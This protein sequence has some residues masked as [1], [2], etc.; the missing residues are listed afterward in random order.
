MHGA[1]LELRSKMTL[2]RYLRTD[3]RLGVARGL[4]TNTVTTPSTQ[5]ILGFGTTF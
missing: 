4:A 3:F 2:F 5:Y 1:S